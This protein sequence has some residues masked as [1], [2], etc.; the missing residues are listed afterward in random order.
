VARL[1]SVVGTTHNPFMPRLFKQPTRP[2]GAAVV[3]ERVEMLRE[4][5]RRA[6]PDVLL[7]IGNDH[8]NQFFMDNM[9]AFLIGKMDAYQ[10]TFYNEEREFGL[11]PC[12]LAGDA[13]LS[14]HILEGA[15]DNGVDLAYSNELRLDHSI[16]VP[17]LWLRPE[18]DL[19][20][21]PLLTNCIA[22]PL[23]RADRFYQV[24]RIIRAVV[25]QLPGNQ[26][27]AAVVS[28]HLSLEIGGPR[29]MEPRLV[30]PDFDRRAVGWLASSDLAAA[31]S[32]C[33]YDALKASG[34]MTHGFMNFLLAAGLAD[35]ESPVY[36]EGLEAGFPAVP[37][38]VWEPGRA[39]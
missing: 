12:R 15:L 14:H 30:D 9:P 33:T 20:V 25:D 19:P 35:G 26:R 29:Q 11:P 7:T 13:R 23:P 24:G 22:P 5:L 6:E 31:C 8:L 38:F 36:A 34:N 2:P 28:G 27:V 21:V 32:E 18:L 16:I 3:M 1:V 10:G 17:L 4:R 37:L 39:A